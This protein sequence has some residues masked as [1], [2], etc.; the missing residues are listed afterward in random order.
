MDEVGD[1]ASGQVNLDSVVDLDERVGE[2][3]AAALFVSE[4]KRIGTYQPSRFLLLPQSRFPP[5]TRMGLPYEW[6]D[7]GDSTKAW[8]N[9]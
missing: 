8:S 5:N 4:A 2:A 9:G 6:G 7:P 1:L 3:N